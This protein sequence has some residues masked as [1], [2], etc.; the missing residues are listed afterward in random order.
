MTVRIELAVFDPGT[1]EE[2]VKAQFRF[3][4]FG[5]PA[6]VNAIALLRASDVGVTLTVSVPELP[7]GRVIEDGAAS[8]VIPVLELLF[9]L[10][11]S[12]PFAAPEIWFLML[13]FPTA[14]T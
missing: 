11:L 13:G 12:E 6:Q 1:T 10:H 14:F 4:L 5:S 2:G 9:A 3:R 8:N 7:K